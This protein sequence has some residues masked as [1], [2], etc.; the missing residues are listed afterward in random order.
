MS[1]EKKKAPN[2]A[3]LSST[4]IRQTPDDVDN[5]N[6]QVRLFNVLCPAAS[7]LQWLASALALMKRTCLFRSPLGHMTPSL[8]PLNATCHV[9]ATCWEY[10]KP[11]ASFKFVEISAVEHTLTPLQ[12]INENHGKGRQHSKTSFSISLKLSKIHIL[13]NHPSS[14]PLFPQVLFSPWFLERELPEHT[15][16]SM[17]QSGMTRTVAG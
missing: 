5:N 3:Q 8:S 13:S 12:K 6:D 2:H 1:T 14:F 16:N 11:Q 9:C 17:L 7:F 10:S 4:E 15:I